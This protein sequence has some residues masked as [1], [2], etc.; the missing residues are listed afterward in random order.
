M[1]VS[2]VVVSGVCSLG[3]VCGPLV[4]VAPL[5]AEHRL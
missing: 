4:A 1:G 2:L 5:V 3:V